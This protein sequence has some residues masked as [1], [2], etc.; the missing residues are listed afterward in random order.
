MRVHGLRSPYDTRLLA[1]RIHQFG[2]EQGGR[3]DLRAKLPDNGYRAK[4][5]TLND[6]LRK[7]A[8]IADPPAN[9]LAQV[10]GARFF[11]LEL[12]IDQAGKSFRSSSAAASVATLSSAK[13]GFA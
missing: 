3:L 1:Q 11:T 13:T 8:R 6:H 7:R 9:R 4:L 12:D 2:A 10:P 5:K